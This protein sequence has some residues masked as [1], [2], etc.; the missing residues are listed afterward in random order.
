MVTH[1][2]KVASSCFYYLYNIR[3][4][5]KYLTRHVGETLV[6]ALVTSQLDYCNSLLYGY[7]SKLLVRSCNVSRTAQPDLYISHLVLPH[8]ILSY[9]TSIG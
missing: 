2:N 4:I 9:T 7:P 1:V 3:R 8:H 6:N 5:R